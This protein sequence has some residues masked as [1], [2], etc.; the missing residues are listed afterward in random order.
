MIKLDS[1]LKHR[2]IVL[3]TQVH[4]VKAVVFSQWLCTDVRVGP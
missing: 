1:I 4:L 2:D 3:P